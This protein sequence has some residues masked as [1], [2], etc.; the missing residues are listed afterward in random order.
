MLRD[1]QQSRRIAVE[2]VAG[3]KV[4]WRAV[5]C[6]ESK[7]CVG[8]SSVCLPCRRM[9]ELSCGLVDDYK[10]HILVDDRK[11][12]LFGRNGGDDRQFV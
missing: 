1:E 2:A 4:E 6:V 11:R 9:N 10:I 7:D 8:N 12:Q 3:V 5:R